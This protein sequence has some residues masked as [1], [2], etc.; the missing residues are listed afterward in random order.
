MGS[1]LRGIA[2]DRYLTGDSRRT[3]DAATHLIRT[4]TSNASPTAQSSSH[5][6]GLED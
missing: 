3:D 2:L 5:A 6:N 1:G 4:A